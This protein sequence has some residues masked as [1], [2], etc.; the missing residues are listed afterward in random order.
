M[1]M[2]FYE[3]GDVF[4]TEATPIKSSKFIKIGYQYVYAVFDT[5]NKWY[6]IFFRGRTLK[7]M[8]EKGF[9]YEDK[10]YINIT[11]TNHY[12]REYGASKNICKCP[13]ERDIE[14]G[15]EV[16]YGNIKG[17]VLAKTD[18]TYY[19]KLFYGEN[20]DYEV[21]HWN[22][23][24]V[25]NYDNLFENPTNN[26]YYSNQTISGLLT[27]LFKFGVDINPDYQRGNVWT[28]EQEEKLIDSIF[29]QINIGAFIFAQKNWSKGFDVVDDMYEIVDGK[30]RITAILHFVQGKIKY[31]GLF[32]YEMH[33]FNR[34]FFESTQ[35][36]MGELN[37][38]NKSYDK[39]E[40]LENFIRLNESGSS[41]D[42]EIIE[43]AKRMKEE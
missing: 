22:D 17:I 4:E 15:A 21:I 8:A 19:V 13:V 20:V 11:L 43:K 3:N 30:Q 32:Y 36:L 29:N 40:V 33:P 39:K 5:R 14:I 26:I 16:N 27:K 1:R 10:D 28:Q 34:R 23:L 6:H 35:I 18:V 24:F 9:P 42:K 7:E 2:I 38:R 12:K 31:K 37:F 25:N 41:M